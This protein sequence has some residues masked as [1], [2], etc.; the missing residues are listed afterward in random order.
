VPALNKINDEHVGAGETGYATDEREELRDY[1]IASLQEAG[2]DV[3]DR[4]QG[5]TSRSW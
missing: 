3:Q 2:I 5:S 1:I 4:R